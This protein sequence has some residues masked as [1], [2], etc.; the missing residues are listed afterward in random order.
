MD[1]LRIAARVAN[2]PT[3][4]SFG[5]PYVPNEVMKKAVVRAAEAAEAAAR[6]AIQEAG[7]DAAALK[8]A[9]KAAIQA[10]KSW[11]DAAD[12]KKAKEMQALA[13]EADQAFQKAA[14]GETFGIPSPDK[15]WKSM[16]I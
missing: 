14:G 6:K 15:P 9:V 2:K 16:R 1:L 11:R 13:Y 3:Y 7:T 5:D 12:R 10:A 8:E 4:K